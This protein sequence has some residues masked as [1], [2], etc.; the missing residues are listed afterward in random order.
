MCCHHPARRYQ[1]IFLGGSFNHPIARAVPY[2]LAQSAVEGVD[3]MWGYVEPSLVPFFTTLHGAIAYGVAASAIVE[4]ALSGPHRCLDYQT[5]HLVR[6][7]VIIH[8]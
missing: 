5:F 6:H 1:L 4:L 7:G 8:H 3:S 2:F